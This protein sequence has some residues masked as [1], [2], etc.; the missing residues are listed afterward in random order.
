MLAGAPANGMWG[1]AG[2]RAPVGAAAGAPT[3]RPVHVG[4]QAAGRKP[5]PHVGSEAGGNAGSTK[6]SPEVISLCL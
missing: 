1:T 6:A 5:F 4:L 3:H 2:G